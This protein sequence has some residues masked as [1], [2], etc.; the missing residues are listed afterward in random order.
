MAEVLHTAFSILL[1]TLIVCSVLAL[2]VPVVV[3]LFWIVERCDKILRAARR[4]PK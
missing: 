4:E 2:A 1:W 3:L